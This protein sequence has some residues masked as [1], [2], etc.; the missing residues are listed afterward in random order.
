MTPSSSLCLSQDKSADLDRCQVLQGSG[1]WAQCV[2]LTSSRGQASG[3][4]GSGGSGGGAG[5]VVLAAKLEDSQQLC[6]TV[7]GLEEILRLRKRS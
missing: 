7:Q 1:Q 3:S 4:G 5:S 2:L 6:R